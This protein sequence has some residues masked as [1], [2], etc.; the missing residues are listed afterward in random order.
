[1]KDE[2][3]IG[4]D[5]GIKGGIAVLDEEGDIVNYCPMP[6]T[7]TQLFNML[8]WL[9]GYDVTAVIEKVGVMPKQGIS[10]S[11]KFMK[12]YGEILG[13]CTALRFRIIE[14]TPQAWKKVMLAGTDK[15]K[16]ASIRQCENLFPKVK[17]I[18]PKCRVAHDGMAE[19]I[20][21]AEYG[22]RGNR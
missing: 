16:A 10:S 2:Y 8:E 20:L 18:L 22:R 19:A 4:I 17:L 9:D 11:A 3:F 6:E 13:I 15:S 14:P 5:P 21:M 12:G 1:M 7:R